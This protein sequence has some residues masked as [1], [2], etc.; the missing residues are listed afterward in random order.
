[1]ERIK[2]IALAFFIATVSV[3][4]AVLLLLFIILNPAI[5]L[6]CF[7][8][9]DKER[10]VNVNKTITIL[11]KNGNTVS[12]PLYEGN[13]TYIKL[14]DIPTHV[15]NAFIAVEDKRF[16]SHNGVD[17][18]R[19]V[20][21]AINNLKSGKFSEGASTITQQL[22]KNTHLSSD[23]TLKRKIN[24]IRIAQD[25]EKNYSKEEILESYF[26]ILYFGNNVYGLNSAAKY[27]FNK[28]ATSLSI[29]EGAL[30]AGI[31]NNPYKFNTIKNKE[32]SIKR[33]NT[34]LKRM[35]DQNYIS[36]E[37][38]DKA[39][40]DSLNLIEC[41]SINHS[42]GEI[43]DEAICVSG[44]PTKRLFSNNYTISS[45]ISSTYSNLLKNIVRN[46]KKD[47][48][49]IIAMIVENKTGN[50]LAKESSIKKYISDFRRSPGSAIKPLLCYASA[51]EKKLIYPASPILDEPISINGYKP[52]NHDG[53]FHGW[54][55]CEDALVHSYNVPAVKLL[56]MVG[57]DYAKNVASNCGFKFEDED[58]SLALSLGGMKYGMTL[59][60]I[61]EGYLTLACGGKRRKIN[62]ISEIKDKNGNCVYVSD[63]KSTDVLRKD[64]A[65]LVNVALRKCATIGSAKRLRGLNNV[66]A[67]TGTVGTN[68]GN[69]DA[70]C[71]AYS[72]N[73][74]VGV[75][76]GVIDKSLM[77]NEMSGSTIPCEIVKEIFCM[78]D[79]KEQIA[80]SDIVVKIAI[81]AQNYIKNQKIMPADNK[82]AGKNIVEYYFSKDN[83][84]Y[85]INENC[86][87]SKLDDF[88]NFKIV[89]NLLQ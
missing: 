24:E 35:F 63:D 49:E 30:L 54:V 41:N 53:K 2:K 52:N 5:P 20:G 65:E 51:L 4:V 44:L 12:D 62:Y 40:N 70:Y 7:E 15:I 39:R 50:C 72:P 46:N 33:R 66:C 88:D 79:D 29:S 25:L 58:N 42:V 14:S 34:V 80:M 57:V 56:D 77:P 16:F 23:K 81:N 73:F 68:N 9:L 3:V 89:N 45:T 74:T 31:I 26:N 8:E 13:K 55:S 48:Y 75:W 59:D 86:Y 76:C 47:D 69:T 11:D 1:M 18:Y 64:T 60:E 21:A 19:I 71:I 78:L 27:F 83:L 37:D 22:V 82:T 61:V 36:S 43:I 17:Y 87:E 10:L 38:F 85:Y 32:I 84:P 28:P 6:P 67:K